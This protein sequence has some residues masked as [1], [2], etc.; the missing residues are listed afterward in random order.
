MAGGAARFMG[1]KSKYAYSGE[2]THSHVV[3][4][5]GQNFKDK[6]GSWGR[7]R[8]ISSCSCACNAQGSRAPSQVNSGAL[9]CSRC[10][11]DLFIATMEP[12]WMSWVG[13]TWLPFLCIEVCVLSRFKR[14]NWYSLFHI[15][16]DDPGT[17]CSCGQMEVIVKQHWL[18]AGCV[19]TAVQQSEVLPV[20]PMRTLG[21]ILRIAWPQLR[22]AR[23]WSPLFCC[24]LCVATPVGGWGGGRGSVRAWAPGCW[25]GPSHW[26]L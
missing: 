15:F 12:Q 19:L 4:V 18:D 9:R 2:D 3:G 25:L 14:G 17:C 6:Q 8:G 16:Q 5:W 20:L 22:K 11:E 13:T 26:P 24:Y 7:G 10:P 23:T 1:E 21:R